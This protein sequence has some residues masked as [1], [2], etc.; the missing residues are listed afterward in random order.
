MVD[1]LLTMHPEMVLRGPDFVTMAASWQ[2]KDAS[3]RTIADELNLGLDSFVFAD[4]S[5]FEAD[6]VAAALPEVTVVHLAGDPA[7]HVTKLLAGRH[8]DVLTST[9]EDRARTALYHGRITLKPVSP[10][11]R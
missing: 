11:V 4:D 5:R 2:H 10:G 8:F 9:D 3:L 1:E 7:G 6:L